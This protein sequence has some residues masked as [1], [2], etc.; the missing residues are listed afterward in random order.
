MS[1]VA[2]I[3]LPETG[4]YPYLR[5]LSILGDA[6]KKRGYTVN[7]TDCD[8]V[9]LRCPMMPN[10]QMP[11]VISAEQKQEKCRECKRHLGNAVKAYGFSHVNLREYVDKQ[12]LQT[13]DDLLEVSTEKWENI[14]YRGLK[15]GQIA[16]YDLRLETKILST[17]N[18]TAEQKRLYGNYIQNTAL[19]TEIVDRIIRDKRVDL[20][21]TYNP[22]AQCQAVKYACQMNDI[23]FKCITNSHHLG[24]NFSLLQFTSQLFTRE[25]LD[26]YLNWKCGQKIPISTDAVKNCFD[27]VLYRM[28]GS[29]SQRSHIFSSIKM[30]NPENLYSQ[31]NLERKR[32]IIGVFT[33]SYDEHLGIKNLLNAWGQ[34]LNE[35]EV[36]KNQTKWLIFLREFSKSRNDLQMIVRIHPRE[37]RNVSSEHLQMLKENF[38]ESTDNFK[39]IWPDNPISSYDLMEIIDG[40]LISSSTVGLE[41]QRLGIPTLSYSRNIS[42]PDEGVIKTAANME[43]YKKKLENIINYKYTFGE[44]INCVRFY[45]W[46][47]FVNSLDMGKS[48]PNDFVDSSIYPAVPK[49]K[50]EIVVDILESKIDLI[51][52]NI[53]KLTL[54]NHSED[55]EL[56]AVKLGIRRIID[57]LFTSSLP[58]VKEIFY[59]RW[60]SSIKKRCC[61]I[62]NEI[63]QDYTLKYSEDVSQINDFMKESKKNNM[64]Y[65]IKDGIYAVF[66]KNG[67]SIRR[68]SKMVINLARIHEET[69]K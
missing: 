19:M 17:E 55:D 44:I 65:L 31:L 23:N 49:D 46:R 18:L 63:F 38:S 57:R 50:L 12:L 40:C 5:S 15:V 9:A 16:I 69:R 4:V 27:D 37:G 43:E 41:C 42:Y 2:L 67:V 52:Y 3:F 6:L 10:C 21:L 7:I 26:H 22:Y 34:S 35:K 33:S 29:G 53:E 45:N 30:Q 36:F 28:Y 1:K 60:F 20:I 24:A 13:I 64:A 58:K 47:T 32:K 61:K 39:V 66:V 14:E 8:G 51:K 59:K 54:A 56:K 62:S 48:I 68:C 11:F 25:S